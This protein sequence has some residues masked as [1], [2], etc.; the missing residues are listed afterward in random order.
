MAEPFIADACWRLYTSAGSSDIHPALL[1]LLRDKGL[2]E[3]DAPVRLTDR[4]TRLVDSLI[5]SHLSHGVPL[6]P[7]RLYR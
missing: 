1:P 3:P 4:G 2:V 5:D 6:P 7:G